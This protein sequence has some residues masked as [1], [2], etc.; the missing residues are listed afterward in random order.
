MRMALMMLAVAGCVERG[1]DTVMP[2][3]AGAAIS[4][5][6]GEVNDLAIDL[7]LIGPDDGDSLVAVERVELFAEPIESSA[8]PLAIVL[9]DFEPGFD[10]FVRAG[11]TRN[12]RLSA[13]AELLS[14]PELCEGDVSLIVCIWGVRPD[15]PVAAGCDWFEGVTPDCR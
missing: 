9:A 13:A 6:D 1:P 3:I 14:P 8:E 12:A 10:R 7:Q 15:A 2:E 11:E 4:I 5:D